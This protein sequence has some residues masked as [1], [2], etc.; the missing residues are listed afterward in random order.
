MGSPTRSPAP[1]TYLIGDLLTN[2][3]SQTALL[4]ACWWQGEEVF[5]PRYKDPNR[6][7]K[8]VKNLE[9]PQED[10]LRYKV[11]VHGYYSK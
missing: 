4:A 7:A 11:K 3:G 8:A 6:V 10:W 5:Y 2:Q 1:T 9:T